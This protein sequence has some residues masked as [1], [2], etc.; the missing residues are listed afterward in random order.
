LGNQCLLA[1]FQLLFLF[2]SSQSG[3]VVVADAD[4]PQQAYFLWAMKKQHN[5]RISWDDF[6][7]CGNFQPRKEEDFGDAAQRI[8]RWLRLADRMFAAKSKEKEP[9]AD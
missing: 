2:H 8:K 1:I 7:S 9:T 4:W 5:L 6:L 3:N